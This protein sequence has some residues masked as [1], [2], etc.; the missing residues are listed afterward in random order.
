[1]TNPTAVF[2]L[3]TTYLPGEIVSLRV[4]EDRYMEMMAQV[5][6]STNSFVTVLISH[7]SEVGGGDTRHEVGVRVTMVRT[8]PTDTG[9]HLQGTAIDRV[10]ITR[11]LEDDPYPRAMVEALEDT[12]VTSRGLHEAASTLT[13][14]GQSIRMLHERVITHQGLDRSSWNA[15]PLLATIAGGRWWAEGVSQDEVTR[16]FWLL[17]AQTPCGPMDR[18]ELLLPDSLT[19]RIT[20]LRATIEHVTEVLTFQMGY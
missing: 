6:G 8:E 19:E 17:A 12:P 4:F 11:W 2:P 7:G 3:G 14:L 5:T 9:L 15:N 18:Y 10:R 16:A 1:M 13:L 20:R